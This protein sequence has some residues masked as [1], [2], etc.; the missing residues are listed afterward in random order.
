MTEDQAETP[1]PA[2]SVE[3]VVKLWNRD[4]L[5]LWQGGLVS[6]MG[7]LLYEIAL[8]FWILAVTGSTGMMGTLMAVSLIPRIVMAPVAGVVAD[9]YNRKR[10]LVFMDLIRGIC[11]VLVGMAAFRGI[12]EIW[13][14]FAAGVVLGLCAGFFDPAVGALFPD[15]VPKDKLERGNSAFALIHSGSRIAGNSIGGFLYVTLGAPLMFLLNGISYIFSSA[16]EVFIRNPHR[17]HAVKKQP[18]M[19]DLKEGYRYVWAQKGIRVLMIVGAILNFFASAGIVLL[20]PLFQQ[21]EMLGPARYGVFM[22]VSAV[23]NLL[24][25]LLVSVRKIEP[26]KRF[27]W[28]IGSLLLFTMLYAVLPLVRVYPVML[29]LGLVCSMFNMV[30]NI[31]LQTIMQLTVDPDKRGKVFSLLSMLLSG[32]MPIAMAMGGWL[33]EFLPIPLVISGCMVLCSIPG[34]FLLPNRDFREFISYDPAGGSPDPS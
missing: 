22:A 11:V 15:L 4:F 17:E 6:M 20:L 26:E 19:Q 28:F 14:V 29:A 18:F 25:M 21:D 12:L 27:R 3:H 10:I 1:A 5:L 24:G 30:V 33:G 32:M 2:G 23:G 34:L 9:R 13:M 8:G 7:D 31:L 16:T